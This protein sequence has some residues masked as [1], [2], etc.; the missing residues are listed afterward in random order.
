M[1]L[2]DL[3]NDILPLQEFEMPAEEAWVLQYSE[4]YEFKDVVFSQFEARLKDHRKQVTRNKTS[5]ILEMG[6]Y[7]NDRALYP[8]AT[9]DQRGNLVFDVHEAKALL[10][11]DIAD[12]LNDHMTADALWD[13][14]TPYQDFSL[15]YFRRRFRQEIRAK[16]FKFYLECKRAEKQRKRGL[17]PEAPLYDSEEEGDNDVGN[18]DS[19]NAD[20]NNADS[21]ND[22]NGDDNMMVDL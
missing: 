14:R 4:M 3:H 11:E 16:K 12:G 5:Q 2:D 22:N 10:V 6:A 1:L 15:D 19:N 20:S 9:H 7:E 17:K 18:A 13:L 8:R 21:N